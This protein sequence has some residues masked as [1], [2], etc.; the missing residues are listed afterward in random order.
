AYPVAS[1]AARQA[2]IDAVLSFQWPDASDEHAEERT[3]WEHFNWLDWLRSADSSCALLQV[4]LT[5]IKSAYPQWKAHDYPDLT[6]WGSTSLGGPESPWTVEQLL[7]KTP[8][9]QMDDLLSFK[10][11]TFEGPDRYG[12][13]AAVSEACKQRFQWAFQ[14]DE[15]LTERGLWTSDLW[16]P[17]LRGWRDAEL[18]RD[19]WNTMF[20]RIARREV[21]TEHPHDV[22]SL[23]YL[24]VRDGGKPFALE[25]LNDANS[26]AIDV[27]RALKQE[28]A[29]EE[30]NDWLSQ[31]INRPAGVLVEFWINGLSLAMRGKSG[32]ERMLPDEHRRWLT[33]VVQDETVA[34]GLGRSVL[35]SWTAF[36]FGLDEA[37]TREYIIPLFSEQ[38]RQKFAQAWDGFL[39]WGQL[40]PALTEELLPAF[41]DALPRLDADLLD[42]RIRFIQFFTALAVFHTDDPT[43]QLL[44]ALF[45]HGTLEDRI[46]FAT[47]IGFF[48]SQMQADT[49]Q[50]LWD[51]WLHRYWQDRLQSVP[52]PLVEAEAKRM[53]EWL[54]H[55]GEAFPIAVQLATRG[56]PLALEH[57]HLLHE[58][59]DSDLVTRFQKATAQLLIFIC[60]GN[61]PHYFCQDMQV[62]ASRLT[63]DVL[64]D[65][66]HRSLREAMAR[67]GCIS[68]A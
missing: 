60:A 41:I 56:A 52:A 64:G 2:V 15:T 23:L 57:S 48:L 26:I 36:L 29:V 24:L 59:R 61:V 46:G 32:A 51:R 35:A 63:A 5:P 43:Q 39:V 65:E 4:A 22:A 55:M 45:E 44:P 8:S 33:A 21:H 67:A 42:R 49:K 9:Q 3:M 40:C 27:W 58:L 54:A 16:P 18:T 28:D 31:A 12:L 14:L 7:A 17:V 6:H 53:L 13:I 30:I 50:R 37:W 25:L 62:I 38:D 34:G 19:E 47:Q 11:N 20:Q 10:G 1:S 68:S 66:L